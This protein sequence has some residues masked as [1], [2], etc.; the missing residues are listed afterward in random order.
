MWREFNHKI[1]KYI[2]END[3]EPIIIPMT[4]TDKLYFEEITG[5]LESEEIQLYPFVLSASK[6]VLERRLKKRLE[7]KN[8]WGFRQMDRCITRLA[9]EAFGIK[10][11]TDHIS[12]DGVVEILAAKANVVL[13]EDN[14]SNLKKRLDRITTQIRHIR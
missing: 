7:R 11:Q 14:R 8:S 12:I 13:Q 2:A 10:I 5:S 4:I 1:I 3:K 6:E 9:D